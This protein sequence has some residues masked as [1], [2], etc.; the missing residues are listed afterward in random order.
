MTEPLRL[1]RVYPITDTHLSGLSHPEQ[2][3][4]LSLGGAE[5]IQLREKQMPPMDFYEEAKAAVEEAAERGVRLILND[6]PSMVRVARASGLHIG[7]D[8]MPFSGFRT[9]LGPGAIIGLSTH[10]V[11]QARE[12]LNMSIDY[13]SIGPI[14]ETSTKPDAEPVVGLEGLR[15]VRE[16][17]GSFPLVAIGGITQSNASEVIAAGADCVAVISALLSKPERITEATQNLIKSLPPSS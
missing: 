16:A 13:I 2:V 15:A 8:K 5:L 3:R 11:D 1:P 6:Q 17:I 12:A 9:L 14:F 7:Q 4:L 10:N